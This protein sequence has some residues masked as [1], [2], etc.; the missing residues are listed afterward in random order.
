MSAALTTH[1]RAWFGHW[2]PPATGVDV[3]AS[4]TRD[5]PGWDGTV[6]PLVGA[7]RPDGTG[8]LVVSPSVHDRVAA[9][10]AGR[11][12]ERLRDRDTR[13]AVGEAVGEEGS[14]LGFGVMRW[15]ARGEDEVAGDVEELGVWLDHRDPRVPEWLH[16]F[17]GEALVALDEDG[18]YAAGVGVKRH[19]PTGHEL[20]VVTDEQHRGRGLAR[21]LVATAARHELQRVPVVTYLHDPANT[22]SA[23]V[24]DAVGFRDRGWWIAGVFGPERAG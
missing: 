12:V 5:E 10:V 16:P 7:L 17:G 24:A 14:V 11:D 3:V 4:P 19:D 18:A 21:R 9:L 8:Q 22:G 13:R 2:D 23:R 6:R 1:L 15:V 20:A